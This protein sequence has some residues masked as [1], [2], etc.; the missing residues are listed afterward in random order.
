[1]GII[2]A[3][4]VFIIAVWFWQTREAA[5]FT[6]HGFSE[7][8]YIYKTT[9]SRFKRSQ[10]AAAFLAQ[11]M[12]FAQ[13]I[14]AINSKQ[15]DEMTSFFRNM[16]FANGVRLLFLHLTEVECVID[17]NS[18]ADMPAREVGALLLIAWMAP[19]GEGEHAVRRFIS[20]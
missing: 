5:K 9:S 15:K 2:I 8:I 1:M 7:W 17:F 3:I 18:L 13:R 10:M 4:I 16:S 6:A 20:N 12:N 19:Y 11:S 14:D